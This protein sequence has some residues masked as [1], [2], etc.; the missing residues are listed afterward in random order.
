MKAAAAELEGRGPPGEARSNTGAGPRAA[1]HKPQ[2]AA[3]AAAAHPADS[4]DEEGRMHAAGGGSVPPAVRCC[5][6][7]VNLIFYSLLAVSVSLAGILYGLPPSH[8]LHA[9][10]RRLLALL[11][12]G[13]VAPEGFK[14]GPHIKEAALL[15]QQQGLDT[16]AARVFWLAEWEHLDFAALACFSLLSL[17]LVS[18]L[19]KSMVIYRRER[20]IEVSPPPV[21]YCQNQM[22]IDEYNNKATT[23]AAI[24]E[25]MASPEFRALKQQR[26]AQGSEAWNWQR[27]GE[28]ETVSEVDEEEETADTNEET[29]EVLA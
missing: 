26:A 12:T 27:R 28:V 17:L 8:W 16:A 1:Q 24:A 7:L 20:E 13:S 18:L 19:I 29:E 23:Y 25:L 2:F 4:M 9:E 15:L 6:L 10:T 22:T 5:S 3:A 21:R 14:M 11:P